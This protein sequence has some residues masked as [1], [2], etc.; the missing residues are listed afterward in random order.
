MDVAPGFA[1]SSVRSRTVVNPV[2]PVVH[3]VVPVVNPVVPVLKPVI[4]TVETPVGI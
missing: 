4:N 2:V 3:P 1:R